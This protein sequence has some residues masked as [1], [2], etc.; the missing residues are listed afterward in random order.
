MGLVHLS[1]DEELNNFNKLRKAHNDYCS[2]LFDDSFE[3]RKQQFR[4]Y[5]RA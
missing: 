3:G 4:K 5:I 1:L 2:K